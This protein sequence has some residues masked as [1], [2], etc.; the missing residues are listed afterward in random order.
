MFKPRFMLFWKAMFV[1]SGP[2]IDPPL[3]DAK[4]LHLLPVLSNLS[5]TN[6]SGSLSF[7]FL[8]QQTKNRV[9]IQCA[10]KK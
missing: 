1:F 8:L 6:V 7:D 4:S 5:D 10:T 2:S 9:K 3:C